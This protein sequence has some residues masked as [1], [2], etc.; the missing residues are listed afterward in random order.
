MYVCIYVYGCFVFSLRI[1][2]AS[3][4]AS[5]N[6]LTSRAYSVASIEP[7]STLVGGQNIPIT[8]LLIEMVEYET[9]ITQNDGSLKRRK[10]VCTSFLSRLPVGGT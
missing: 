2:A 7:K 4:V 3:F 8:D 9:G 1:P 5:M 6:K 10:G